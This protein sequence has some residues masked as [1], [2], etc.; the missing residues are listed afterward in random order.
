MTRRPLTPQE[1]TAARVTLDE[2]RTNAET[3]IIPIRSPRERE[4]VCSHVWY[5]GASDTYIATAAVYLPLAARVIMRM[6][7]HTRVVVRR[8][9]AGRWTLTSH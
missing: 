6:R 8:S 1:Y 4:Y 7:R 2:H 5:S 9:R 3:L